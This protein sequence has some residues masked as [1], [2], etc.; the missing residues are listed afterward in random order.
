MYVLVYLVQFYKIMLNK[1]HFFMCGI[2]KQ[3]YFKNKQFTSA[4]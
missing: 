2:C 4:G 1:S 3:F